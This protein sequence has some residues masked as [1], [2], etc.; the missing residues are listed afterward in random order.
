MGFGYAEVRMCVQSIARMCWYNECVYL[1]ARGH[2]RIRHI[3]VVTSGGGGP[4]AA[5]GLASVRVRVRAYQTH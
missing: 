5:A 1:R 2:A 4:V 3:E